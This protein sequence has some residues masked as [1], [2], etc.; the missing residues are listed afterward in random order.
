MRHLLLCLFILPT[1]P[2][3]A[4]ARFDAR[5]LAPAR[6][7]ISNPSFEAPTSTLPP[8]YAPVLGATRSAV[9]QDQAFHG[10]TSLLIEASPCAQ[11]SPSVT[12][13]TAGAMR[14]DVPACGGCTYEL[15]GW[16]KHATPGS[17]EAWL[18]LE[19]L[20]GHQSMLARQ[21]VSVGGDE[22]DW[23]PVAVELKAPRETALVRVLIGADPGVS[24]YVDALR[25][26]IAAGHPP[27]TYKSPISELRVDRTEATWVTLKWSG[28]PGPYEISYRDRRRPRD[29]SIVS[30]NV[31]GFTY[32]LVGL[33]PHARY[34]VRMRLVRPEHYDEQ[35]QVVEPP[36]RLADPK[37][38]WVTTG[39]WEYRQVGLLRI[40]PV[41]ALQLMDGPGSNARIEAAKDHL[42]V[43]QEFGGGIHLSKLS[44][45]T[46]EPV[47]TRQLVAP[48]TSGPAP[49]LQDILVLAETLYVLY[50]RGPTE[51]ALVSFNLET[52]QA[53]EPVV[54]PLGEPATRIT[55]SSL[56]GYRDQLWVLWL[57]ETGA[58]TQA[59]GV[60]RL[61]L[62]SGEGLTKT[63]AWG[64][65]LIPGGDSA[66]DLVGNSLS[67][68]G[69]V[70]AEPSLARFGDELVIPFTDILA[71][72]LEPGYQPLYMIGFNGL[73]FE[74][75]R[76]LRDVGRNRQARGCQLGPN[77]YLLSASDANYL[78]YDGR[79]RDLVLAALP[80][81]QVSLET[82]RYLDDQKYD[83]S[84]DIVALGE[85][86][87]TVHDKYDYAPTADGPA[88]YH[89]GIFIGRIDFGPVQQ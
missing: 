19:M 20:D 56:A 89:F 41:K 55:G 76:K 86:L 50:Q 51:L 45:T 65:G 43:A 5:D 79:Y 15:S 63:Y 60:L 87:W 84:P 52:E 67:R 62:F 33:Q 25:L 69:F 11:G 57:D 7:Q 68:A 10:R 27:R 75:L 13:P 49:V 8:G 58:G 23:R 59:R 71:E 1:A 80:P 73:A 16:I 28:P 24:A 31:P 38:L 37:P 77:F 72:G 44:P 34:E 21:Q 48:A 82:I 6:N 29:Q 46:L 4:Q 39:A 14:Q 42:Y 32:S 35:G 81:G 64:E 17:G 47:W 3:L 74:R 61:A 36:V 30:K 26:R 22:A 85:S 12:A 18:A 83:V 40:W 53:A 66:A 88:P 70:P 54:V 2:A 9:S 78:T